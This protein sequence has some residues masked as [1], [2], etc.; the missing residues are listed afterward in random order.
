M[1]AWRDISLVWLA[2]LTLVALLP[3]GVL[4][5]YAVKGL[6]R[7]RQ[8]AKTYLPQA[9]DKA[10]QVADVTEQAGHKVAAPLIKAKTRAAQIDGV[11]QAILR[12]K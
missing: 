12:R 11:A 4:F 1:A 10:R 9:Q 6:H 3:F 8:L 7:L 2:F 5:F